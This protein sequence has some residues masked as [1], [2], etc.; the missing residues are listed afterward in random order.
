MVKPTVITEV[1]AWQILDSRGRPTV[2]TSVRCS[3]G[4]QGIAKVPSGASRGRHEVVELRD[5]GDAW[6][7]D[8]VGRAVAHVR[9][10]I[11]GALVGLDA[12]DQELVDAALEVA[13][14]TASFSVLGGNAVVSA[15]V[16]AALA[17]A[18]TLGLPLWSVLA[19]GRSQGDVLLPMPMVNI[20]SGGAHAGQVIDIQDVLVIPVGARTFTEALEWAT[21]VRRATEVVAGRRG[22]T[23]ALVADEG[24]IAGAVASNRDAL[25]LV[26]DGVHA[27]GLALSDQVALAV[28]IAAS[29]FLG[30]DGRYHFAS[31]GRSLSGLE[32]AD[33]VAEWCNDFG[34]ISVEDVAGEDDWSAWRAASRVLQG[35]QIVGDDLFVTDVQR[36]DRGIAENIGTSV[37]V[38]VN[39][40]GTLSRAAA[41]VSRAQSAGYS[42]VVSARSGDTEDDWLADLAVG[43]RAGQ[44][45]VGSTTRSER[46]AKWNRLLQLEHELQG[47]CHLAPFPTFPTTFPPKFPATFQSTPSQQGIDRDQPVIRTRPGFG[48]SG[49]H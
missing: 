4:G 15:S 43:W 18:D 5:G 32:L 10:E 40:A 22:I 41:V 46:T 28:D 35:I 24:G 1:D 31:E 39:Q 29:Q 7:G 33:E 45:K 48:N 23:T 11:A 38:K 47:R 3:G 26:A 8:G 20:V 25:A 44:I 34:V 2:A 30:S 27:A 9:G 37:L 14:G 16:A 21:R 12:L 49:G 13:D 36:L 6:A 42:C 17:A 19:G